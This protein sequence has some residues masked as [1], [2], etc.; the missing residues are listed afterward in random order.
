MKSQPKNNLKRILD[1]WVIGISIGNSEDLDKYGY[2][3]SDI[4][5]V[6]IRLSEA[7]LGEGARL[8]FGHDWR[9]DGVMEAICNIAVRCQAPSST[10]GTPSPL[11][12]NVLAW[13]DKPFLDSELRRELEQRSVLK[14]YSVGIP[15]SN[16]TSPTDPTARAIA[17][18]H[19][20]RE[21]TKH[22]NARVCIGGKESK[23][24]GFFAGVIEDAYNAAIDGEPLFIGRFLGGAAAKLVD[25]LKDST[26]IAPVLHVIAEKENLF[27]QVCESDPSLVPKTTDLSTAFK[28][29]QL[30][31]ESGLSP[32]D[33]ESLL[34][35]QDIEAFSALVI[36]GLSKRPIPDAKPVLPKETQTAEDQSVDQLP[37]KPKTPRK[38]RG[39]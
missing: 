8:V 15:D 16:W 31:K 4:N 39:R 30:Q 12:Q 36:R 2:V 25:T 23:A 21:M 19:M 3:S 35:A 13:P 14:V 33:W 11:I 28:S 20:R 22:T 9:P 1:G 10:K 38:R 18:T 32:A 27:K 5:R 34:I 26:K 29:K 7:L 37:V 17:L 6:T 24:E